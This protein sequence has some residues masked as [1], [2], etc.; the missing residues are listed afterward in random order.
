LKLKCD[1]PLS[2]LAFNFNLRR[3]SKVLMTLLIFAAAAFPMMSQF[4]VFNEVLGYDTVEMINIG[5]YTR[6]FTGLR[7]ASDAKVF[8]EHTTLG[9]VDTVNKWGQEQRREVSL[10][11]GY[12]L[13]ALLQRYPPLAQ[14][15]TSTVP[16]GGMALSSALADAA[17]AV[18]VPFDKKRAKA[19]GGACFDV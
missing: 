13:L 3:Y 14:L 4:S 8:Q 19:G 6:T 10:T 17:A 1:E 7:F 18:A 5:E 12:G 16:S 11:N 9:I 2:N 15:A